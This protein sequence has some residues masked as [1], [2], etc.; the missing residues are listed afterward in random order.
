MG[1]SMGNDDS[2]D[3]QRNF[4][5]YKLGVYQKGLSS[6]SWH[7][8]LPKSWEERK[9][10]NIDSILEDGTSTGG[11]DNGQ[12]PDGIAV[13]GRPALGKGQHIRSKQ[14]LASI[15]ILQAVPLS[16]YTL[17]QV[18]LAFDPFLLLNIKIL[19]SSG[20]SQQS[21]ASIQT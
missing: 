2:K 7:R 9:T 15:L 12:K 19:S 11:Q 13:T 10:V 17:L 18:V 21:W 20:F 3:T 1:E 14:G 5:S 4:T 8:L 16:S 6:F